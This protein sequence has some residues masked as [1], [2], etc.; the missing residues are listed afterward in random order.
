M[1]RLPHLARSI[2]TRANQMSK[3]V[4]I[5]GPSGTGKSTLLK[6]LFDEYPDKFGFSISRTRLSLVEYFPVHR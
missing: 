4:V 5:C 3:N 6:R 1:S 2:I